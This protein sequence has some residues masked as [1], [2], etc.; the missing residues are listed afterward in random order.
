MTV[1]LLYLSW[2][3]FLPRTL[4]IIEYSVKRDIN[5]FSSSEKEWLYNGVSLILSDNMQTVCSTN[6]LTSFAVLMYLTDVD[7]SSYLY[8]D[9]S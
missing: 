4:N 9:K 3:K 5:L 7:V 2:L 1:Y 8:T 6:H